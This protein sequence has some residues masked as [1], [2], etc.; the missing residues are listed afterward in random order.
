MTEFARNV[1]VDARNA[2]DGTDNRQPHSKS[3]RCHQ[4]Q[5]QSLPERPSSLVITIVIIGVD[6]QK[7]SLAHEVHGR[8]ADVIV[9]HHD[10]VE[11]R[12]HH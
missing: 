5:R 7:R 1:E 4:V 6:T 8:L 11:N 9:V 12:P 10:I 2:I 3:G